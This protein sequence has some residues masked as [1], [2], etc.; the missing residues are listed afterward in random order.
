V[1]EGGRRGSG[2]D[3]QR[4]AAKVQGVHQDGVPHGPA[5]HRRRRLPPVLLQVPA[6]QVHP[7]RMSR[8]YLSLSDPPCVL[9]LQES[10]WKKKK[11]CARMDL[12]DNAVS[13]AP[14]L[15][16]DMVN[17]SGVELYV[18]FLRLILTFRPFYIL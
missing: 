9:V 16:F 6:L 8:C 12:L 11:F 17:G 10:E 1:E 2:Q 18:E 13:I 3:V 14:D 5:L 4:D 15:L 7:L